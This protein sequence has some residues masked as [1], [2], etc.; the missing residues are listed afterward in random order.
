MTGIMKHTRLILSAALLLGMAA[1]SKEM[2]VEVAP[3]EQKIALTATTGM[4]KAALQGENGKVFWEAGDKVRL[5]YTYLDSKG[6]PTTKSTDLTSTLSEPAATSVFTGTLGTLG[7]DL[8]NMA[9][10]YWGV[11]PS[12]AGSDSDG[13]SVTAILP[14]IQVAQAGTFDPAA[15]VTIGTSQNL[16]MGFQAVGGG[17]RFSVSRDDIKSV[18]IK[19][20]NP[21]DTLAGTA[22]I[23][24]EDGAPKIVGTT[25]ASMSVVL[26]APDGQTFE[27]GKYYYITTFPVEFKDGFEM[28]FRTDK[29][30]ATRT[31]TK[32]VT[33]KRSTFGTI[34]NADAGL[35]FEANTWCEPYIVDVKAG[36]LAMEINPLT[37]MPVLAMVQNVDG[38]K[39][40]LMVYNMDD[41]SLKTVSE[42]T[43]Q[44]VSLGV[45]EN[46]KAYVFT[47]NT[48][49]KKGEVYT[50]SDLKTW[51]IGINNIDATNNWY[52]PRIGT[53]GN[54]AF[55][56]TS[57]NAAGGVPKRNV[58]ITSF[59]GTS[60]STGKA[61][62]G[63]ATSPYGLYP[64]M[65]TRNGVMYIFVTD[66]NTGLS[67]YKYDGTTWST[68]TSLIAT[69][70][71]YAKYEFGVM[72]AQGM[73]IA[74]DGQIWLAIATKAPAGIAC[75]KI[76]PEETE[77]NVVQIGDLIP[78]GSASRS[79][80]I[81]IGGEG[82][83]ILAYRNEN[84]CLC[85]AFLNNETWEW[86]KPE[87]VTTYPVA[88]VIIRMRAD[89]VPIIAYTAN[90]R[91]ELVTIDE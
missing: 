25:S 17:I 18:S 30:S 80:Q 7:L 53:L 63:R 43:S 64:V 23:I 77:D 87:V 22:K 26:N 88:D 3:A 82:E 57:N 79:A 16:T 12:K 84:D 29:K 28:T 46:G 60:W 42:I 72:E 86:N 45:A 37:K 15:Y 36:S 11:Y 9:K 74:P 34:D 61:I 85:T 50:S 6:K 91:T 67:I 41:K 27:P 71:E 49:T 1:C 44:Y 19:G 66:Y 83:A 21:A 8:D 56:M 35:K 32:A 62:E 2:T 59:N 10:P 24:M 51:A 58:N 13:E 52:G 73:A 4:T 54:E 39:G 75:I 47:H 69:S 14:A 20:A 78:L 89:G 68:V 48:S 5:Y 38:S 55:V 70:G 65:A 90:N 31:V 76:D 33:I 40:P 81:A